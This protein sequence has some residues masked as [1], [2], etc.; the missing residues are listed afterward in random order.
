MNQ[1][2]VIINDT[3]AKD[4][5]LITPAPQ[6]PVTSIN[7]QD[8]NGNTA[9]IIACS[10]SIPDGNAQVLQL[11]QRGADL[12]I[13]NFDGDTALMLAIKNRLPDVVEILLNNGAKDNILDKKGNSAVMHACSDWQSIDA[14]KILGDRGADLH[15]QNE[16][17][18]TALAIASDNNYDAVI[19]LLNKNVDVNRSDLNNQTPLMRASFYG[20]AD[21]VEALLNK[22]ATVNN[23]DVNGLTA[24]MK[25][26]IRSE[27]NIRVFELLIKYGADV[28]LQD[29]NGETALSHACAI[30]H[31]EVAIFL[32]NNGADYNLKNN[33]GITAWEV[34]REN[35]EVIAL[36]EHKELTRGFVQENISG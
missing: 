26:V 6:S 14:L 18:E 8:T 2:K 36:I 19:Y 33:N 22:G 4:D 12:N 20:E 1:S 3:N 16:Q 32:I 31:T 21:I 10:R 30:Y 15:C 34:A 7:L 27:G 25:A 28:N 11:I 29:N 35:A 9:L 17:G 5:H 23:Q 13:Q 24:L